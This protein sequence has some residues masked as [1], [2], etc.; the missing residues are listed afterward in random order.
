MTQNREDVKRLAELNTLFLTLNDK[1]QE[2]VLTVLRSLDFAQ[3]VMCQP[4]PTE[5][6]RKPPQDRTA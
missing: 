1:G 5:Q 2:S 4:A 3:S 6:P